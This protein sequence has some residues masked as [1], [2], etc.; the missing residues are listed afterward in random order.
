MT[1][2]WAKTAPSKAELRE[3]VEFVCSLLTVAVE[4][5]GEWPVQG[6]GYE[7][8]ARYV[9]VLRSWLASG[10]TEPEREQVRKVRDEMRA[11]LDGASVSVTFHNEASA[12]ER[13]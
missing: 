5:K 1:D 7:A 2:E 3:A 6:T 8:A 13:R 12:A 10:L 4:N 11:T 9:P